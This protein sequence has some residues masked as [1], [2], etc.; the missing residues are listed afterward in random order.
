MKDEKLILEVEIPK[1][2]S[3]TF[4]HKMLTIK[5][6]KGEI[7]REVKQKLVD[8]KIEGDKIIFSSHRNNRT[9]RKMVGSIAAHARN[10]V[11]GSQNPHVYTLKICSGHF[12]M[13]VAVQGNKLT[14]KNFL[15]EKVARVLEIKTGAEVKVNGDHVTVTCASKDTA[16]QVAADIE[17]L[18]RRPGFDS[19]VFQDGIYIINKD[20]EDLK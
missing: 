7:K 8:T 20:G 4:S 10:M 14:V 13:T 19:R 3:A 6:P 15:G 1:G 9:N 12:P 16:G 17:Q 2:V 11:R 5:G 18:I